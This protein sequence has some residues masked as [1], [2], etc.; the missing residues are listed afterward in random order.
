MHSLTGGL[1]MMREVCEALGGDGPE[2][3]R[4]A[5]KGLLIERRRELHAIEHLADSQ[6]SGDESCVGGVC[7]EALRASIA[8]LR[9]AEAAALDEVIDEALHL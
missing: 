3:E 5:L 6:P 1:S 9:A 7:S 2:I 4:R 8:A